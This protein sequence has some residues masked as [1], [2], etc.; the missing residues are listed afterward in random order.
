M[1]SKKRHLGF[2][3]MN[4]IAKIYGQVLRATSTQAELNAL[5]L[6]GANTNQVFFAE[7]ALSAGANVHY[8]DDR[9]LR[10]AA[11]VGFEKI[12]K[13]LLSSYS[14]PD[15]QSTLEKIRHEATW[16]GHKKIDALLSL[17]MS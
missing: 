4:P 15:D 2:T 12:A 11:Y 14:L 5:L 17:A 6:Y 9:P 1:N 3:G 8:A 13:V 10:S 7:A 16:F